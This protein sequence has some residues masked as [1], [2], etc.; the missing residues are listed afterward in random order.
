MSVESCPGQL[1]AKNAGRSECYN[2][3]AESRFD[4]ALACYRADVK[5]DATSLSK[6][7][8]SL[9]RQGACLRGLDQHE[10]AVKLLREAVGLFS[11]VPT[12]SG[13]CEV[14]VMLG[15]SLERMDR[16]ADA[17]TE[18][19][20]R[21][22]SID[23]CAACSR[24]SLW[25]ASESRLGRLAHLAGNLDEAARN[26]TQAASVLG[27][28]AAERLKADR[29]EALCLG[30]L[31]SLEKA[32][33]GTSTG[34]PTDAAEMFGSALVLAAMLSDAAFS[35]GTDVLTVASAGA[36]A[37]AQPCVA[38]WPAQPGLNSRKGAGPVLF[39]LWALRCGTASDQLTA[40]EQL[41][42]VEQSKADLEV[43]RAS[44]ARLIP[45]IQT[46]VIPE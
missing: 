30:G 32:V 21:L 42:V 45:L 5:H 4:E 29:A 11:F 3:E 9:E 15:D 10:D 44:A 33:S 31:S 13:R 23:E 17:I 2:L 24:L 27:G 26:W 28:C 22:A 16:P 34:N 6:A 46:K 20:T 39:A 25:E 41:I 1:R 40:L 43:A 14:V 19:W 12:F 38:H 36:T 8:V 37:A 7:L 35:D 18:G